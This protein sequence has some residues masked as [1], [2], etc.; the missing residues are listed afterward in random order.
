MTAIRHNIPQSDPRWTEQMFLKCSHGMV[1]Y[2][3]CWSCLHPTAQARV[4]RM[5]ARRPAARTTTPATCPKCYMT[6]CD[7]D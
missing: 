7:C 6:S 3:G 2:E 4:D 1:G 5:P